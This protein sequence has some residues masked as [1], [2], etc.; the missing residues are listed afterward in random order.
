[1]SFVTKPQVGQLLML[2]APEPTTI[3][4]MNIS[5]QIKHRVPRGQGIPLSHRTN[6]RNSNNHAGRNYSDCGLSGCLDV[7]CVSSF[8]DLYRYAEAWDMLVLESPHPMPFSTYAWMVSYF[9]HCLKPGESWSCLM[10]LDGD[11]LAGVLPVLSGTMP[12]ITGHHLQFRTPFD[13]HTY[14]T[15]MVAEVGCEKEVARAF[16]SHLQKDHSNW[17]RLEMKRI[18]AESAMLSEARRGLDGLSGLY[19]LC[20]GSR[21]LRTVGSYDDY[22]RS[23]SRNFRRAL[24]KA[25]RK[26]TQLG[27]CRISFV[28]SDQPVE[29]AWGRFCEVD[30]ASWKGRQGDDVMSSERVRLFYRA[31]AERLAVRGWLRWQ[32]MEVEG[33]TVAAQMASCINNTLFIKR[34]AYDEEYAWCSPGRMLIDAC[35]RRAFDSDTER[36]DFLTD[37]PWHRDWRMSLHEN[38]HLWIYPHRTVPYALGY[39]PRRTKQVLHCVPGLAPLYR[40]LRNRLHH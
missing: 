22:R 40:F 12:S 35:V 20:D 36:V 26:L 25:D 8:E 13:P 33:R 5:G 14:S 39:M 19:E 6:Y 2:T 24:K 17:Y 27:N 11:R 10:A 28:G 38:Y 23:L 34:I 18:P 31:L 4:Y 32:F 9:E 16:L 1:M 37:M 21:Y 30:A 29:S 3:I 15:D 7:V